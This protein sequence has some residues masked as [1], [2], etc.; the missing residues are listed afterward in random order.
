MPMEGAPFYRAFYEKATIADEAVEAEER[1]PTTLALIPRDVSSLL[2]VGCGDGTLLRSVD[3]AMLKVGVD[4]SYTALSLATSDHRVLASSETLPFHENEFD[5]VMSTEV[6]EHLPEGVFE[7]SCSEIQRVAR[8]YVLLSVPFHED[9]AGKQA[10]CP[11]CGHVYHIHLHLRSFD[12]S[13]LEGVF[14]SYQLREY[15]FSGPLEKTYPSWLL[16]IRR[17][18]GHR[19]EW[20]KAALCP[21]CGYNDS[22]PPRRSIISVITSLLAGLIGKRYPKWISALYEKK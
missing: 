12:L 17:K 19:W 10:H 9:L 6:L 16:G 5:L 11:R 21:L 8:R 20:D 13:E 3:S 14:D 15:R 4:I 1:T 7:A 18:Y 22:Q 2:D